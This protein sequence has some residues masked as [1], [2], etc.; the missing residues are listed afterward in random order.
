MSL[1]QSPLS[2]MWISIATVLVAI[3]INSLAQA[4]STYTWGTPGVSQL[5][6]DGG[7]WVGGVGP[8]LGAGPGTSDS[9]IFSASTNTTIK[10][11]DNSNGV[12]VQDLTF[13]A[14]APAYTWSNFADHAD[15]DLEILLGTAGITNLSS[16]T[17]DFTG[18]P[19][20]YLD[21]D[22]THPSGVVAT[23]GDPSTN[24]SFKFN[25]IYYSNGGGFPMITGAFDTSIASYIGLS[26]TQQLYKTGAGTL[27][28]NGNDGTTLGRLGIG[29]SDTTVAGPMGAVRISTNNGLGATTTN[30]YTVIYGNINSDG[31]LEL[32]NNITTNEQILMLGRGNGN[33]TGSITYDN[34]LNPGI[35]NVSG[36]NTMSGPFT[37]QGGGGNYNF[38]S[39]S[40]TLTVTS[41]I[42]WSGT[43]VGNRTLTTQ[44]AGN[45]TFSGS[46]SNSRSGSTL[47]IEQLGS[48][49]LTLGG[50]A[51]ANLKGLLVSG[52]TLAFGASATF[53]YDPAG[54]QS[55]FIQPNGALNATLDVSAVSG[56]YISSASLQGTGTVVG[57]VQMG[58]GT[59]VAP[60]GGM[61][62]NDGGFSGVNNAVGQLHF[63]N[64]LDL[65]AGATMAWKLGAL[66]TSSPGT[67]FDQLTVG[68]TL[69]LGGSSVL[70]ID[71]TS[72]LDPSLQPG[73]GDPFWNSS[74][75]W[76]IIS[77]SNNPGSSNFASILN[78][79]VATGTFTTSVSSGT[80]LGDVN[81]DHVVNG[82]DIAVVASHWL[83]TGAT[84][85][86]GDAN[87]DGTVNGLDIAL[88]AS[89]WLS[90]GGSGGGIVLT[91]TPSAGGGTAV[92]E[93][94]TVALTVL[95]VLGI[96][97]VR[98]RSC[99]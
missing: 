77:N 78:G 25:N 2:R 61:V 17:Q 37:M 58:A 29:T 55:I 90:T 85:G 35:V 93:P 96:I 36:N 28:I 83:L 23:N 73:G 1:A 38:A 68:G 48:G 22:T 91:Y 74:H 4:Q 40:G 84:L 47:T 53:S 45:I 65:S 69:T 67:N 72:L 54:T 15:N 32:T 12:P 98:R 59:Q 79:V 76:T 70:S 88:I 11:P 81:G 5:W 50:V 43:P 7:N 6:G 86:Q 60:N 56:G 13:D 94:S 51:N 66:S 10:L 82:L 8:N 89:H 99:K 49:T 27:F 52:G 9:A 26:A 75:T 57:N 64:G 63:Q 97:C 33:G 14:S 20:I 16:H 71:L 30:N 19:D 62:L 34:A 80:L 95:S 39:T 24:L 21:A 46:L 42:N 87:G 44:G 18:I 92:P 31:R 41:D 3:F